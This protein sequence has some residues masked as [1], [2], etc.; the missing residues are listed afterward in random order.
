MKAMK[1]RRL[2]VLALVVV[3]LVADADTAEYEIVFEGF[4]DA[5]HATLP[6]PPGAHFT[7]LIGDTHVAGA[8]L[9]EEGGM[10]TAGVEGVAETGSTFALSGEI[11][12]RISAGT[13]GGLVRNPGLSGFPAEDAFVI[14]VDSGRPEVSLISM[15]APTPDWFI[16]VSGLALRDESGWIA[17]I[18]VDLIPY[19]AGTEDGDAF[20]LNNSATNP[21]QAIRHRGSPFLEDAVIARLHFTRVP[22][23]GGFESV[24]VALAT[25]TL[26]V[27]RDRRRRRPGLVAPRR[28]R[29]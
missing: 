6:F 8:A 28:P 10:A 19:D 23:A 15:V 18:T 5:S 11:D 7:T 13:S 22:E 12:D 24:A 4:W 20:S 27:R 25:L 16:G 29:V 17:D 2:L 9:W 26:V 1:V 14:Q 3:P 21:Q